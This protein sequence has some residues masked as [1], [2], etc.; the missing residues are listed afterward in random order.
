[1]KSLFAR[2]NNLRS[3][4]ILY[5][6]ALI[7]IPLVVFAAFTYN[8]QSRGIVNDTKRYLSQSVELTTQ[9]LDGKLSDV[10]RETWPL[11]SNDSLGIFNENFSN[12]SP[13]NYNQD[14]TTQKDI[15]LSVTGN[16][17][18]IQSADFISNKGNVVSSVN[19]FIN[20]KDINSDVMNDINQEL[21]KSPLK[22][23]W[24]SEKDP[25]ISDESGNV[26]ASNGGNPV[27]MD[28]HVIAARKIYNISSGS[29][30]GIIVINFDN[31]FLSQIL[32][33]TVAGLN[34][35]IAIIDADNNYILSDSAAT[36]LKPANEAILKLVDKSK[37][38]SGDF[39]LS[40][41][42]NLLVYTTSQ[43]SGWKIISTMPYSEVLKRDNNLLKYSMLIIAL[44]GLAFIGVSIF[45]AQ[46]ISW[47]IIKLTSTMKEA[48]DGDLEV[49]VDVNGI[50][51]IQKLVG[52][53]NKM[54]SRIQELLEKN[55]AAEKE[56]T[57]AEIKALQMRINPHFLYNTLNTLY[58]LSKQYGIKPITDMSYA[59]A[60]LFRLNFSQVNDLVTIRETMELAMHYITIQKIRFE[61]K[62]EVICDIEEDVYDCKTPKLIIQPLIENAIIHG[63]ENKKG[64]G[65]INIVG[66][67]LNGMVKITV[68]DDGVGIS[69]EKLNRINSLLSET[70]NNNSSDE[71]SALRNIDRRLKLNYGDS[72]GLSIFSEQD[73]CT[74]VEIILPEIK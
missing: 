44:G 61:D 45:V 70:G 68:H 1:M 31:N 4:L 23:H 51:E 73:K 58:L 5:F 12:E 56:K 14:Y 3:R 40:G 67:K 43:N 30:S 27:P 42:K 18:N 22:M 26:Q 32:P 55:K 71:A 65:E 53:F 39:E 7:V 34:A 19:M 24:L 11:I 6:I 15:L 47:P 48:A 41:E 52:S 2:F 66:Y 35:D 33:P 13:E 20:S 64:R 74:T 57:L 16:N 21:D 60:C 10:D 54:M 28:N 37:T 17:A 50:D 9:L 63:I 29:V 8:I 59:I 38:G 49:R 46:W 72:Y 62:L 36:L 69:E 25:F